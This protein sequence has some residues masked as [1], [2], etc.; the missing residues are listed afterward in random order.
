MDSKHYDVLELAR[1][2]TQ[3]EI[4]TAYRKASSAAHPDREGGSVDAQAALNSAYA[5]LSDPARREYYDRTGRDAPPEGP[6]AAAEALLLH[7]MDTAICRGHDQAG[8]DP[9]YLARRRLEEMENEL[10]K[11]HHL[12]TVA[13]EYLARQ[14]KRVRRK[15]PGPNLFVQAA[16]ARLEAIKALR[17]QYPETIKTFLLARQMFADYMTDQEALPPGHPFV[18]YLSSKGT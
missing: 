7:V 16:E 15:T 6:E 2:A 10:H 3:A 4:K 5:V 18:R 13:M 17:A 11:N 8:E 14:I 1:N 12:Q 9:L